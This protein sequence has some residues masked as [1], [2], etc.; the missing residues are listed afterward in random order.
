MGFS[1]FLTLPCLEICRAP[2]TTQLAV[3]LLP[4]RHVASSRGSQRSSTGCPTWL[5]VPLP[6]GLS[7]LIRTSWILPFPFAHL[8]LSPLRAL[9]SSP[10]ALSQRQAFFLSEFWSLVSSFL[11]WP[12]GLGRLVL[13]AASLLVRPFRPPPTGGAGGRGSPGRG[14]M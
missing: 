13:A 11:S 14:G 1:S 6:A 8:R 12:P 5:Q 7:R 10:P 2:S 9:A 4:F 3:G